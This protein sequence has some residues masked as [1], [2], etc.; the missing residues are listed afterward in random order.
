MIES[1]EIDGIPCFGPGAPPL[2]PLTQ[3][4]FLYGPNGLGKS[5][6]SKRLNAVEDPRFT[7]ELFDKDFVERLLRA[8]QRMPGVF[9][10]R[11]GEP[12]VQKR[13]DALSGRQSEDGEVREP[14]EIEV[15]QKQVTTFEKSSSRQEQIIANARAVLTESCWNKRKALPKAFQ[16]AFQGFL[17]DS[18]KNVAEVLSVRRNSSAQG[19]RSEE[20][21]LASYDALGDETAQEISKI[22]N[23][24]TL[25]DITS[26]QAELLRQPIKSKDDSSFSEFV[27]LLNNS[28]WIRSGLSY[29]PHTG[30]VCPFCQQAVD[31]NITASLNDLFDHFYEEQTRRVREILVNEERRLTLV[32]DFLASMRA[33]SLQEAEHIVKAAEVLEERLIA[34][35]QQVE[36]KVAA[37]S[38]QVILTKFDALLADLREVTNSANARIEKVNL[39]LRD[40]K[41]AKSELRT[42]VWRYYVHSVVGNDLS[43]FDGAVLAPTK[44]L[45]NLKPKLDEAKG[46]LKS[47][48]DEL[49]DLQGQLT[50]AAPTVDAMNRTL[51]NLGFLNFSIE[52][53][54][55]DDTYQ[56]VR[57]DGSVASHTLSVGE[58]SLISFLYYF[59][60][61]LRLHEDKSIAE[62]IVAVIDDPVSSLDGEMLFVINLLLR[63]IFESCIN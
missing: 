39:L 8:D 56:L 53:L 58:R 7:Q 45:K 55:E 40:R 44:A 46:V 59:H 52:H 13:I 14:G 60:R 41:K 19:V 32:S 29:L 62:G 49:S 3:I 2:Q 31:G 6:I 24:P 25:T 17:G 36:A 34:R 26:E 27:R 61:L 20:E 38:S 42:E 15:A 21:L 4:T 10:I 16:Q 30:G 28:D 47:K 11:D 54:D 43:V 57:P 63:K 35:R 5:S 33:S 51:L 48:R 23:F 50:S 1:L 12:E 37:P 18:G 22:T 9:V